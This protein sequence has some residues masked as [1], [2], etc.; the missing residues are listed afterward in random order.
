MRFYINF[1]P[2]KTFYPNDVADWEI[3]YKS[4]GDS[5][6]DEEGIKGIMIFLLQIYLS[7]TR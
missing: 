6:C 7:Y 2:S 4:F 1:T 3:G 5:Y